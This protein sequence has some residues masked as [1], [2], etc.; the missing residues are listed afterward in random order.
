MGIKRK[1]QVLLA[2]TALLTLSLATGCKGFFVNQPTALAVNPP[3]PNLGQGQTQQ[4]TAVAT[5]SDNTTSD[6]TKNAF[7]SS[8]A[9]C[10]V[11]VGTSSLANSTPGFATAIGTGG[12]VTITA[13]YNGVTATATPVAVTGLTIS[14]CGLN[15]NGNFKAGTTQTFTALLDGSPATGVTWS[16]SNSNV[17]SI[18]SSSGLASFV[19]V[20]GPVT[21]TAAGQSNTGQLNITVNNT[22]Q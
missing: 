1:L 16:S 19:T 12:S 20:G 13:I 9:P 17:V 4:F 6:V 15:S 2:F 14:P 10:T 21:I 22:G 18:N 11:T 7:W 5:F 3:S 8:S